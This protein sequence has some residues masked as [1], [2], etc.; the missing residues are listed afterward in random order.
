MSED[1]PS[2][3]AIA[4]RHHFSVGRGDV[5][6]DGDDAKRDGVGTRRGDPTP[7]GKVAAQ[8]KEAAGKRKRAARKTQQSPSPGD[9]ESS[10][11]NTA[12]HAD[13]P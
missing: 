13:G 4:Q 7:N 5:T 12:G 11:L 10:N 8:T 3:S 9:C 6:T 2:P 1:R